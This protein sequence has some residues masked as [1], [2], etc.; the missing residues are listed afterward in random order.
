MVDR[1]R[2]KPSLPKLLFSI[3]LSPPIPSLFIST[4]IAHNTSLNWSIVSFGYYLYFAS[5]DFHN[6]GDLTT[7]DI[8]IGEGGLQKE[9]YILLSVLFVPGTDC[10]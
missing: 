3:H 1:A 4:I 9:I 5:L 8:S 2:D 6:H 10:T 7:Y